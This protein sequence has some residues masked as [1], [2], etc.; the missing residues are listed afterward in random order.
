[1]T[2]FS[3]INVHVLKDRAA[4]S[5]VLHNYAAG[6]DMRDWV[7]FR[8]C[9]TEDLEADFTGVLPGN[10]CRGADKWVVAAQRL[11]APLT[12]TQHIISNHVHAID[13]D[14]ARSRSYLQAQHMLLEADGSERH[15]LLGGYYQY[16]MVR[17]SEGWK[18]KKYSLTK[19]WSSGDPSV[20][21]PVQPARQ[22]AG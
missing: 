2:D 11:I 20:L 13:G 15:Y 16:D 3:D 10:V 14:T 6:V 19:T 1:M 4:L 17:T 22:M 9:F 7:L 5:D 21:V 12:A 8:S 18:I